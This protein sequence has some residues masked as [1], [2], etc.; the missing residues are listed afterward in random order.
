MCQWNCPWT[1]CEKQY[2]DWVHAEIFHAN[3]PLHGLS[4]DNKKYIRR[5]Q[6]ASTNWQPTFQHSV[7]GS[8]HR[9]V[10]SNLQNLELWNL[11]V[12]TKLVWNLER[13]QEE[14][15]RFKSENSSKADSNAMDCPQYMLSKFSKQ[16]KTVCISSTVGVHTALYSSSDH[17]WVEPFGICL[18]F[19]PFLNSKARHGT[20][21]LIMKWCPMMRFVEIVFKISGVCHWEAQLAFTS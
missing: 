7:H 13:A 19:P 20:V 10:R 3:I 4:T 15:R 16:G 18:R 5:D 9:A 12:P 8:H 14:S 17:S 1:A 2:H 11:K 21:P 6:S